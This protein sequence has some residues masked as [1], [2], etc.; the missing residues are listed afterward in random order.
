[1]PATSGDAGVKPTELPLTNTVPPTATPPDVVASR[2]LAVVSVEFIIGS[3]KVADIEAFNA[4]PVAA[5]AG[6]VAM[7]RGGV[8]SV[9]APAAVVNI[10]VKLPP[11]ALPAAS[12]A[13]LVTVAMYW[14]PPARFA[15]GVSLAV[16]P[17]TLTVPLT[18]GPP[19]V[20]ATVKLEVVSVEFFMGSVKVTDIEEFTAVPVVYGDMVDTCGAVVSGAPPVVKFQMKLAPSALPAASVAPVVTVAVNSVFA[21]RTAEGVKV[22]AVLLT[23]TV[24][25]IGKPPRVASLKVLAFS[26]D[27]N[28]G[29]EKLA[30]IAEFPAIWIAAL[31]GDV[32]DTVGG[33][34]STAGVVA[35][36]TFDCPEKFPAPSMAST[37]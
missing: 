23:C 29:S 12:C 11:S 1:M 15:T 18:A 22:A 2:T 33:V 17:L 9:A 13:A 5:L 16:L 32:E 35:I 7:T 26:V 24:P 8:V 19:E 34:G 20:G 10:Q 31:A 6:D 21:A 27:C 3:V 36:A 30:V 37:V 4:T 14:V 28:I 25:V